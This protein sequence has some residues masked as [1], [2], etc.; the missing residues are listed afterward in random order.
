MQIQ[1]A[2]KIQS[3]IGLASLLAACALVDNDAMEVETTAFEQGA[4]LPTPPTPDPGPDYHPADAGWTL[5]WSDEFSGEKLDRTKWSPEQSCW[6]GGNDERQCYTDRERNIDLTNG[7]LRLKAFAESF[8][9]PVM[10]PELRRD[11]STRE[12]GYTSGKIRSLGL[13]SW[14]YGRFEVRAKVPAG[15][16]T[17]PAVWMMP[18]ENAY[19]GWPLSGEIDILEAVNIGA[20]CEACEGGVGENRTISALHFGD[21]PP[22]NEFIDVRTALA[23]HSLP[24]EGFHVWA[25][26]WGEGKIRFFLNGNEYFTV[27]SDDWNTVSP[28]ADGNDNAPFDQPFYIMANLAVGGRLSEKNN[29]KGFAEENYPAQFLIDWIRVY[30]CGE[31]RET[32]LACMK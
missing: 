30:Q 22:D 9:G 20:A 16:G 6:G 18:A 23:D 27:T 4:S 7:I 11:D 14:K 24:S 28:L 32:G 21:T 3:A 15:Q 29:E 1:Q 2:L 17:W 8:E 5:I 26:E 12:Q 25:A 31:D 10:P 19:G 13:A